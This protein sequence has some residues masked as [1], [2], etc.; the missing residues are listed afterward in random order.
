MDEMELIDPKRRRREG[1]FGSNVNLNGLSTGLTTVD[2][3]VGKD[4]GP[5]S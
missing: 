5:D 1:E 3:M 4:V 2:H